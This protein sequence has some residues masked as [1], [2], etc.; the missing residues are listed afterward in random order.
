MRFDDLYVAGCGR[1]FPPAMTAEDAERAGLCDRK[2]IWR[3]EF[4][5][6]CVAEVAES[7]SAP[8][9]AARA[10]EAAL[11][12]AGSAPDEIDL[13]LH[14]DTYYQGY[15]LWPPASYVQRV[16]VGNRCP[17]IEIRQMSNGGMAALELAAAY[18]TASPARRAALVTTGDR[19]CRPG[20]D[21]WH[22]D[23][24]TICGDGGTAAVLSR[25]SGYARLRS[26][27]T[28]CDPSL[29]QMNR[30]QDPPGDAPFSVRKP[31]DLEAH[32]QDFVA[33]AGLDVVMDRIE[34]GQQ[35]AVKTALSDAETSFADLDRFVLPSMGR[36]RLKAHFLDPFGIDLDR[37][38]WDWGRHIGHL[39]AGDQI[40]G[41]GYLADTGGLRPGQRCLLAGVGAG[42]AFSAAVVEMLEP[43]AGLTQGPA[44]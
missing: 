36:G 16:A 43:P 13:V 41:L 10:A 14:A 2:L 27:V 20:Y 35:E 7:G 29:E 15:D 22:S 25:R 12:Q 42:F 8:E 38:T 31:I 21:R 24:G 37:T 11:R 33:E 19:F 44:S 9:M 4:A 1:W 3:S 23:L 28:V 32:R 26:L 6:V 30:G 18:L 39:G 40:A 34:A 5:S 17:A